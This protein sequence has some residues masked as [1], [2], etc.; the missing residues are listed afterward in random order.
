MELSSFRKSSLSFRFIFNFLFGLFIIERLQDI[1]KL[2]KKNEYL[3][4]L[5][6]T[7]YNAFT[8]LNISYI[9]LKLFAMYFDDILRSF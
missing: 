1:R 2:K 4:I 5:C 9:S 7:S 8:V 6:L 3:N